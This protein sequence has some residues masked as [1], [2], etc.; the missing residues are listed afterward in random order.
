MASLDEKTDPPYE[1][2]A[3]FDSEIPPYSGITAFLQNRQTTLEPP[4]PSRSEEVKPAAGEGLEEKNKNEN[5]FSPPPAPIS[6]A[7]EVSSN[8]TA[9]PQP[10]GLK[11]SSNSGQQR[12]EDV[13]GYWMI[14]AEKGDSVSSIA[15]KLYG[16]DI[17]DEFLSSIKEA[18]PH[19]VNL[20]LIEPG[21]NIYFP[22]FNNTQ[23]EKGGFHVYGVQV[24]YFET[25]S[26]AQACIQQISHLEHRIY[27]EREKL[28][29]RE[30]SYTVTIGPFVKIDEAWDFLEMMKGKKFKNS[31]VIVIH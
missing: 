28:P 23:D 19:I 6:K 11:T 21:Q 4:V 27:I 22:I 17:S 25:M 12:R 31:R 26:Q 30:G 15:S 5:D 20:D 10:G 13:R 2:M 16:I 7:G 24:G 3:S 1:R 14:R 29:D 8:T 18:N 9:G